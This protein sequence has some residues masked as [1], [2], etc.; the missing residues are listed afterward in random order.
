[1]DNENIATIIEQ[2]ITNILQHRRIKDLGGFL[3]G[4]AMKLVKEGS[5]LQ[6][7]LQR[8]MSS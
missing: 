3:N 7:L 6:K 4:A 8:E 1:L 2:I 5:K